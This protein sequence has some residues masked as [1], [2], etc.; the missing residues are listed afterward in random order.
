MTKLNYKQKLFIAILSVFIFT[1]FGFLNF[2]TSPSIAAEIQM[3]TVSG[4]VVE[5]HN[6]GDRLLVLIKN[7]KDMS[8]KWVAVPATD[9]SVGD[10]VLFKPGIVM[11]NFNIKSLNRTYSRIVLS[12]G[13]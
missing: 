8:K 11:N 9:I 13:S 7:R 5:A 6:V 10:R 1:L 2:K 12:P 4:S 3:D